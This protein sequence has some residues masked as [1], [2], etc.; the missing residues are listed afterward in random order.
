MSLLHCPQRQGKAGNRRRRRFTG[1]RRARWTAIFVSHT[2][3]RARAHVLRSQGY[4][5]DKQCAALSPTER[6]TNTRVLPCLFSFCH[7]CLKWSRVRSL[8][9]KRCTARSPL[10][11]EKPI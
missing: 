5:A 10:F 2:R 7:C 6:T 11:G 1:S 4:H 3:A 9:L 8:S